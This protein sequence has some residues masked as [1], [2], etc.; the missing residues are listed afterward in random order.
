MQQA[1][2]DLVGLSL[3]TLEYIGVFRTEIGKYIKPG[4]RRDKKQALPLTERELS[5]IWRLQQ[6]PGVAQEFAIM[7][8]VR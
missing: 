6:R 7:R 8:E 3:P 5:K 4:S 1:R 2:A